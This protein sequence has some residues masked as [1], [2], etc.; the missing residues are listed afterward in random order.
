MNCRANPQLR[1]TQHCLVSADEGHSRGQRPTS[2]GPVSLCQSQERSGK[3]C[4]RPLIGR[5]PSSSRRRSRQ[6]S[7]GAVEVT[8]AKESTSLESPCVDGFDRPTVPIELF[9]NPAQVIGRRSRLPQVGLDFDVTGLCR[10][11][12]PLRPVERVPGKRSLSACLNPVTASEQRTGHEQLSLGLLD[13]VP[14]GAGHRQGT[15]RSFG[16]FPPQTG[17]QQ[18]LAQV[19]LEY[20]D[21][22]T[23]LAGFGEESPGSLEPG[24]RGGNVTPSA[25]DEREVPLQHRSGHG[26]VERWSSRF[27]V[28]EVTFGRVQV[29]EQRVDDSPTADEAKSSQLVTRVEQWRECPI[30]RLEPTV[31]VAGVN[32]DDGPLH[33]NPSLGCAGQPCFGPVEL[34]IGGSGIAV[35]KEREGEAA[36]DVGFP[37][38]QIEIPSLIGCLLQHS[39]GVADRAEFVVSPPE[40]EASHDLSFGANDVRSFEKRMGA[41]C[42]RGRVILDGIEGLFTFPQRIVAHMDLPRSCIYCRDAA[43]LI[44][45]D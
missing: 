39:A 22:T 9:R 5:A 19:C 15:L 33:D 26:L 37:V 25:I 44:G 29:T 3:P 16:R 27:A 10:P 42:G 17:Q 31:E 32:Q 8:E 18:N 7:A 13:H 38:D 35:G 40:R 41:C 11:R 24:K 43:S 6:H 30:E 12:W 20:G 23:R 45:G 21:Q 1:R 4:L 36:A 34:G 2:P 14:A 28:D